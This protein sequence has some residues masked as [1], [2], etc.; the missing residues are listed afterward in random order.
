MN[1]VCQRPSDL[2]PAKAGIQRRDVLA[3]ATLDPCVRGGDGAPPFRI[4][5]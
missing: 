1:T 5:R 2:I 3:P 4:R